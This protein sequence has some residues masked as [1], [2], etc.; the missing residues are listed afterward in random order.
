MMENKSITLTGGGDEDDIPEVALTNKNAD[1]GKWRDGYG[2]LI[3]KEPMFEGKEEEADEG[4]D[5]Y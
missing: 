3:D 5:E 4:E 1:T 2:G